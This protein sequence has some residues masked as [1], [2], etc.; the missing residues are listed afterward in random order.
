MPSIISVSERPLQSL[1]YRRDDTRYAVTVLAAT[2][3]Q[4]QSYKY[5]SIP[6][7]LMFKK[8]NSMSILS[9]NVVL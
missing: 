3:F 7:N 9:K 4:R 1:I 6:P 8:D 5:L 2:G